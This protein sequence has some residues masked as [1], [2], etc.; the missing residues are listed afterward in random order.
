MFTFNKE[1][2]IDNNKL[3]FEIELSINS[4]QTVKT[5]FNLIRKRLLNLQV[6]AEI[7]D[8]FQDAAQGVLDKVLQNEI[9]LDEALAEVEVKG[10][11]AV[12]TAV[13]TLEQKKKHKQG[14]IL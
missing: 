7:L 1:N 2:K 11:E 9:T 5:E 8:A 12:D 6:D 14:D 13:L 3:S 4:N 10:Q